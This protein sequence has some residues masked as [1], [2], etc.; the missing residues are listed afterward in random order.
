MRRGSVWV[1]TNGNG[2]FDPT[3]ADRTNRDIVYTFGFTSDDVFAAIS[4]PGWRQ[5]PIFRQLAAY[6][7]AGGQFAG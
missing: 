3:N 4:P 5:G 7:K 1:D 6:G 2:V